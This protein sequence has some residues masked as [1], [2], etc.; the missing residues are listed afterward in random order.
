MMGAQSGA[1]RPRRLYV[2]SPLPPQRNGLADYLMAYLPR[3]ALEHEVWV[4]APSDRADW[5]RGAQPARAPWQVIDEAEFRARQPDPGALVLYNLG[6]NSDCVYM[7]DHLMSYPGAVVLHDG[8]LFHLHQLAVQQNWMGTLMC[9]WLTD[10]GHPVPKAFFRRDGALSETPALLYQECLMLRRLLRHAP[11]VLVHTRYAQTRLLG[12]VPTLPLE[13]LSLVPHFVLPAEAPMPARISEVLARY[14]VT[15]LTRL[16]LVPGFLTGNKMLYE[17]LAAY[18]QVQSTCPDLRLIFAG[19]E[20]ADEYALS[21][22]IAQ[23]WPD[24]RGPDVTGYLEAQELDILLARADLSFVLRYPTYGEASGILPRAALGGGRVLT[25]DIGAYPEF[26]SPRVTALRVGHGLV[27]ALAQAM[28]AA[29][30]ETLPSEAERASRRAEESARQADLSP[31]ALY[32]AWRA[33]LY[34]C[35]GEQEE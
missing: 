10:D 33:W 32:P 35:A 13:R 9:G 25:V 15:P 24:G 19:E 21:A 11:G 18:R 20:R 14:R 12:A 34:R 2:F 26:L 16:V 22:R 31:S 8:S 5:L 4:V 23:W 27:A 6:N 29:Q 28:Q 1:L 7:L 17:V 30:T 3:L